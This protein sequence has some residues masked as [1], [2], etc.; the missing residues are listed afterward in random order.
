M[1]INFFDFVY[2]LLLLSGIII[3]IEN[4]LE[5]ILTIIGIQG[6]LLIFP[7]FQVHQIN[8]IHAWVLVFLILIFKTILPP[9]ILLWSV[10]KSKLSVHTLPRFGY[11]ATLFSFLIGLFASF[12]IVRSLGELPAGINR[13]EVVYIFLII[14][15]GVITFIVRVHWIVLI[16]GFVMFENGIFLL[17]LVLQKGLPFGIEF[18]AFIDALLIIV[19]STALQLRGDSIKQFKGS[20]NK[21]I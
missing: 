16:C 9:M 4:R 6:F 1:N 8:D 14:Y 10:K 7:V 20:G 19:A 15:L 5:R 11:F 21:W 3:L 12:L 17:T 13:I 2:L 18:G